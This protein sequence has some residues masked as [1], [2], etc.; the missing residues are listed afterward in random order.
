MRRK[1]RIVVEITFD[2]PVTGKMA[3]HVVQELLRTGNAHEMAH[4]KA[5]PHPPITTHHAK[6]GARVFAS[7]VKKDG[8]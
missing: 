5:I 6:D 1:H 4:G 7:M 2:E 8:N 3:A